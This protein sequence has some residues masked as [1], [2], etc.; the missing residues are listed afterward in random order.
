[1]C[2]INGILTGNNEVKRKISYLNSLLRHRGPDDE[3]YAAIDTD[4]SN[5]IQLSGNDSIPS[6]KSSCQNI[7]SASLNNYDLIFGHRRLSI[8]DLSVGGH[9]PMADCSGK[10]WI[11]YN[12]EIYNY[13]ELR[14]ELKKEGYNFETESDTEVIIYAYKHWGMECLNKFN[15][16]W[17]FGLWDGFKKRL[18]LARDRF[19]VKPLYFTQ[20][21]DY[22]AF[23]SEIKTLVA[24][25]PQSFEVN[26]SKI[27]FLVLYG[28]RL[29]NEDTYVN[30]IHTLRPSHSLIYENK[31]IKIKRYYDI[32]PQPAEKEESQNKLSEKLIEILYDSIKLRF[33]SDVPVGTC[34]SGGFDSSSIVSFSV[35]LKGEG[36]NTFSAVWDDAMSDE[37]KYIDIVNKTYDCRENKIKPDPEEFEKVFNEI[38][39]HQEIPTE[40]PGLYPQWYVMKKA[41]EKV[42]VLLDGQGGDEVFGGYFMMG[43]YL[44][45]ILIDKS[46]KDLIK[47]FSSFIDFLNKSGLHSFSG[48]I[49][50]KIYNKVVRGFLSKR[51]NILNKDITRNMKSHEIHYDSEPKKIFRNYVNN[52]SYHLI[53]DITIPS[54]LHY[55]DRSSMAHSIESRVPFLDYRL[56]EFGVNLPK[57]YLSYKNVNR[58]LYRKALSGYLPKEVVNRTD[59]L[60]YP[61]PFAQWSRGILKPFISDVLLRDNAPLYGFI[62]KDYL[63]VILQDHF[64]GEKDYSWD[65]WRMLSL[66]RFLE[67]NKTVNK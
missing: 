29:N 66:E 19:G 55:E 20:T 12:G 11:T 52:Q 50:P 8:I 54:L 43:T 21:K 49:F 18:L 37:S 26:K 44:R 5:S 23:S 31:N 63:K 1:M 46:Y 24:L 27:P 59:K 39:Y 40:G 9:G 57:K 41:K 62:D 22:F 4:T 48:W 65:I 34:L 10:I 60:G 17:A 25:N 32:K 6:V 67:M 45:S 13:I 30:N 3:G 51:K 56:V 16:M 14:D 36:L 2:G 58:P 47:D 64:A 61:T 33:R 38:S 15:G 7:D 35:K 53:N 42:K 28:N